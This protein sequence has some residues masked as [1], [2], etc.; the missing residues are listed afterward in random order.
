MKIHTIGILY[1]HRT[2]LHMLH[3]GASDPKE[4]VTINDLNLEPS[5]GTCQGTI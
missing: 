2:I 5:T 4:I 3:Y 1:D